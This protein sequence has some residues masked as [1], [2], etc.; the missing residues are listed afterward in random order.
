MPPAEAI[1]VRVIAALLDRT[2]VGLIQ[3]ALDRRR[4]L[5]PEVLCGYWSATGTRMRALSGLVGSIGT[6]AG[7][8]SGCRFTEPAGTVRGVIR[9]VC[10]WAEWHQLVPRT[11]PVP[12]PDNFAGLLAP[13]VGLLATRV[14]LPAIRGARLATRVALSAVLVALPAIRLDLPAI[15]VALPAVRIAPPAI[16]LTLPALRHALH[17]I[18]LRPALPITP[19]AAA[20]PGSHGFADLSSRLIALS[21]RSTR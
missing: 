5:A 19:I 6:S 1:R 21:V 18:R 4:A 2:P 8:L 3:G 16:R 20:V 14:D 15:R 13:L 9:V 7:S 12:E 11:K 17:P 10:R